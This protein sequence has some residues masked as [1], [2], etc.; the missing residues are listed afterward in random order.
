MTLMSND[1]VPG[2]N[3]YIEVCW[4]H[5]MPEPNPLILNHVHH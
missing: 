3:T 2:S 4:I 1:L 5:R